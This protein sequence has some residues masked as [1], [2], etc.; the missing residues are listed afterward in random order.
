ML[1]P[2]CPDQEYLCVCC[3]I[4]ATILIFGLTASTIFNK[5][6][7][8]PNYIIKVNLIS[9]FNS[10]TPIYFCSICII[11]EEVVVMVLVVKSRGRALERK[12]LPDPRH[13]HSCTLERQKIP[14]AHGTMFVLRRTRSTLGVRAQSCDKNIT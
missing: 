1:K 9:I 4:R 12:P 2:D 7:F 13:G 10:V 3:K 14:A 8:S 5:D 6:Y 11:K